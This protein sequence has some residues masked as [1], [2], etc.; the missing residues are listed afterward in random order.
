MII[1]CL[2][3]PIQRQKMTAITVKISQEEKQIYHAICKKNDTTMSQA[4]RAYIR[5]EIKKHDKNSK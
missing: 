1:I 2:K 3:I 4:I 5:D